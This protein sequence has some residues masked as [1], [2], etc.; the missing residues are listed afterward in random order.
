MP[1]RKQTIVARIS[2]LERANEANNNEMEALK[3]ELSETPD[4]LLDRDPEAETIEQVQRK[5]AFLRAQGL[6]PK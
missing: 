3:R 4:A 1:T 5:N 2:E 6:I